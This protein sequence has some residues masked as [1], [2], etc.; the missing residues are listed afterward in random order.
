MPSSV[1]FKSYLVNGIGS[2]VGRR[3][4]I[5]LFSKQG[6]GVHCECGKS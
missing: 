4:I 3:E 6:Q 2:I 1:N 5:V